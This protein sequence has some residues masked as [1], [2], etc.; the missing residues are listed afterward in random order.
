MHHTLSVA[1]EIDAHTYSF[2]FIMFPFA[3]NL[4][5]LQNDHQYVRKCSVC[6]NVIA[7]T[8]PFLFNL[9]VQSFVR[10]QRSFYHCTQYNL[11]DDENVKPDSSRILY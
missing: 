2:D 4:D 8:E 7:F 9:P 10:W 11:V 3:H 5:T 6:V 1:I